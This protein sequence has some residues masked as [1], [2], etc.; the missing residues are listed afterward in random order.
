MDN[1][2]SFIG[3][4]Y[5]ELKSLPIKILEEKI[6]QEIRPYFEKIS[7]M[8]LEEQITMRED[9]KNTRKMNFRFSQDATKDIPKIRIQIALS[10]LAKLFQKLDSD[11]KNLEQ[12]NA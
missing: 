8:N 7:K 9:V 5:N 4:T 12:R 11:I 6:V 10:H 3:V 2:I 1:K